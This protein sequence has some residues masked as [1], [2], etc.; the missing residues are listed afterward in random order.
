MDLQ[1]YINN[2]TDYIENFKQSSLVVNR[3]NPYLIVK[4]RYDNPP[5]PDDPEWCWK[6]YCRGAIINTQTN[7][8]VCLP[9]IRAV[10]MK[11]IHFEG[12]Q[13][14]TYS[15][16]LDGTMINLFWDP[17]S[18]KWM[19]CTRS[20]IGG[21]NK[22][23]PNSSGKRKS[24]MD[25]FKDCFSGDLSE[26][27]KDCSYSLVMKHIENRNVSPVKK[28]SLCLVEMYRYND[29]IERLQKHEYPK[30][31]FEIVPETD[32]IPAEFHPDVP[33]PSYACKGFTIKTRY[34]RYKYINP[35]YNRVKSLRDLGN[36][37]NPYLNFLQLRKS[38][39]MKEYLRY[40]PEQVIPFN[41]YRENLHK[42][43]NDLYD[44]YKNV[45]IYKKVEA[46]DIPYHL[47]PFVYELHGN[48]LKSQRENPTTWESVK[49]FVYNLPPKRLMYSINFSKNNN[50]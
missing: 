21:Y 8:I 36:S 50:A 10:E 12:D 15:P 47:K 46:S 33:P 27:A 43:T 14:K 18:E 20:E 34:G 3:K 19:L 26:L 40:Y 24:F 45:H 5:C 32:E 48:Y 7:K 16:L 9:P 44:I 11:D 30:V 49:N 6:R 1:E 41:E 17:M 38:G 35:E 22:W 42:L 4:Y 2:H 25:M 28:N 31:P 37:N 39:K 23:L 29:T 13:A